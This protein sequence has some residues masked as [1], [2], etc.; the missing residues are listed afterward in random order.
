MN[1]WES[2]K[3]KNAN[4]KIDGRGNLIGNSF[5]GRLLL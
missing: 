4:L 5:E 1:D 3:S 2:F